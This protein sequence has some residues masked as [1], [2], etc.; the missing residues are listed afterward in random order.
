MFKINYPITLIKD[1][2]IFGIFCLLILTAFSFT[3][4]FESYLPSSSFK[5]LETDR[6]KNNDLVL[7]ETLENN[8]K[9]TRIKL[10]NETANKISAGEI[11][12]YKISVSDQTVKLKEKKDK[13]LEDIRISNLVKEIKDDKEANVQIDILWENFC[14]LEPK[15]CKG[16]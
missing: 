9:A 15:S 1:I 3:N 11:L 8:K 13:K 2:F 5:K 7:K 10:E 4:P 14:L 16:V 6:I 12:K